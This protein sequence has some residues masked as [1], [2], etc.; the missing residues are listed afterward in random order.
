MPTRPPRAGR[1]QALA[2]LAGFGSSLT[3]ASQAHAAQQES[4]FLRIGTGNVNGT[5]YQIGG[6]LA[7]IVSN[8]PGTR[9][10]D[11]GGSCGVPGLIAIAQS[12]TGS[13]ANVEAIERG[14]VETGLA[15][16]DV[17]SFAATATGPF[18]GRPP[19]SRLRVLAN[20]YFE[21]VHLVVRAEAGIADVR[22]LRGKRVS[23]DAEGSGTLVDAR[24]V[25]A[26]FGL[27][28]SE[29]VA[30]YTPLGSSI[31]RMKAGEL[32]AFFLV[33]GWPAPAV[34]ELAHD[35]GIRLVPIM[36]PEIEA[37]AARHRFF[38]RDVIPADAYAGT[39][40]TPTIA[41]GAQWYVS[42]ELSDDLV[43]ALATALWHPRARERLDQGHPRGAS[44]RQ[45][46]AL[47][48]IALPLHPGAERY[49]REHGLEL[50]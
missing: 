32:D 21:H 31:D 13:V 48:G 24:L 7:D 29:I 11:R 9:P 25:L 6:L 20:L 8:P 16:S 12:S 4:R 5:Y 47:A 1:R 17:A 42:S 23:L 3:G 27:A 22:G 15:Q 35:L 2:I 40:A 44:I 46:S 30:S 26:A 43:H 18:A 39:A 38:S 45:E 34:S 50:R 28:E 10:C 36:G 33:A 37:L 41:V 19:A 49:Y 14:E